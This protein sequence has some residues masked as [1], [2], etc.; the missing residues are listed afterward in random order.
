M[1]TVREL[2]HCVTQRKF[3]TWSGTKDIN[4]E[5]VKCSCPD[6]SFITQT[7]VIDGDWSSVHL[8][9]EQKC[10]NAAFVKQV[11][12]DPTMMA[13]WE[14]DATRAI[15]MGTVPSIKPIRNGELDTPRLPMAKWEMDAARLAQIPTKTKE[16][17]IVVIGIVFACIIGLWYFLFAGQRG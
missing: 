2:W 10:N 4:I 17:G 14:R 7:Q 5:E 6:G 9:M 3:T 8:I 12:Q 16:G 15:Q 11:I 13:K 1:T